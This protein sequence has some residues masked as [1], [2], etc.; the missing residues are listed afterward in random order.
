MKFISVQCHHIPA[1]IVKLFVLISVLQMCTHPNM[2]A[3]ECQMPPPAF[4]CVD[5]YDTHGMRMYDDSLMDIVLPSDHITIV[6]SNK[7]R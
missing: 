1:V 5:C 6:C 2:C 7:V 3:A 4:I